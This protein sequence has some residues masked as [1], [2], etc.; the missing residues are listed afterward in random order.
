MNRTGITVGCDAGLCRAHFHAT[1]AQR[2]GLLSETRPQEGAAPGE[3]DPYW[4]SCK[5]HVDKDVARV[6]RRNWTAAR[7]HSRCVLWKRM[8]D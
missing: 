7:A 6:N 2:H 1:C 8:C 5:Q 4:A 3:L